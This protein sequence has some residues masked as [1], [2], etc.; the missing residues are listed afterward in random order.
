MKAVCFLF[1][2]EVFSEG[3]HKFYGS[4]Q[5]NFLHEAI[6][7]FHQIEKIPEDE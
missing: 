6:E 3:N 5:T 1:F 4:T 2:L 7:L